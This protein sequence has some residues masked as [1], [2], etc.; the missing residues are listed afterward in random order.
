MGPIWISRRRRT[1]GAVVAALGGLSIVPAVVDA[2]TSPKQSLASILAAARAQKS[3][4]YVADAT[5]GSFRT[6]LVCDVGATSG[7]Q[8]ITY[9]RGG[10]TGKVTVL[11]SDGTAYLRGDAFTLRY[12]MGFKAAPSAKFAGKWVQ[13]PH[14]DRDYTAL[15]A[16]VTLP[17]TIDELR[18]TEPL[19]FLP[20]STLGGQ[21]VIGIK[22]KTISKQ[23][24]QAGL[25][26][27]AQGTPLPVGEVEMSGNALS[28]T[29]FSAW[30]EPVHV[31]V[32]AQA[33]AIAATGL[34]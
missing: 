14:T 15:A 3:V 19:S 22:G 21:K 9:V 5:D 25:Y 4:H 12:Y 20:A 18:L 8:R 11:V 6:T 28:R 1:F 30:N 13:V 26:T 7:I 17:S 34:E 2:A 24:A 32:P 10:T 16:A 29:R 33:V 31:A 23:P 27:R